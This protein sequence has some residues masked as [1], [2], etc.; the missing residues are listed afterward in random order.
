MGSLG[1]RACVV[2]TCIHM[3]IYIYVDVCIYTYI[4]GVFPKL[5]KI[6]GG[7]NKKDCSILVSLYW[8]GKLPY[9]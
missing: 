3:Y 7:P 1:F 9:A 4:R 8:V 6:F 5:G 2:E